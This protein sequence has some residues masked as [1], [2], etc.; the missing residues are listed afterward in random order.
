MTARVNR[1]L[2]VDD[3]ADFCENLADIFGDRGYSVDVAH[4]GVQALTLARRHEYC[5]ALLDFRM[6]GMNGIELFLELRKIAATMRA[7]L[8]S[9]NVT[10]ELANDARAAG[11]VD[12]IAKPIDVSRLLSLVDRLCAAS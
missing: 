4:N 6:P 7:I 11:A 1:L 5:A 8:I 9:A 12:S 10:P 3:E 2:V